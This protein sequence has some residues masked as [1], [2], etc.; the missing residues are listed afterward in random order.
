MDTDQL[1]SLADLLPPALKSLLALLALFAIILAL[2][3]KPAA[4]RFMG[5]PEQW[6]PWVRVLFGALDVIAANS[7]PVWK[8][9]RLGIA[10]KQ[11]KAATSSAPPPLPGDVTEVVDPWHDDGK[12]GAS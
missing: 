11:L 5:P 4:V 8:L 9:A 7:A 2:V 6:S 1:L 3:L 10:E 12:G